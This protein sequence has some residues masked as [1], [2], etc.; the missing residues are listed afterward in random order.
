MQ[1]ELEQMYSKIDARF[2]SAVKNLQDEH[3]ISRRE[4]ETVLGRFTVNN[5]SYEQKVTE[6]E[7]SM[8]N[9]EENLS[10]DLAKLREDQQARRLH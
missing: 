8:R 7:S 9:L 2:C 10:Q 3:A 4:V 6:L 5:S 1:E